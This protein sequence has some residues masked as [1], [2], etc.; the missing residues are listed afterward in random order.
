MGAELSVRSELNVGST[1]TVQLPR[2]AVVQMP[3]RKA[4]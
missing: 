3:E 1:F 2:A 4:A